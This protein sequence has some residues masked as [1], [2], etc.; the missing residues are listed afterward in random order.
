MLELSIPGRPGLRLEHL[1]LDY[2]GTLAVDGRLA[3][4]VRERLEVLA[5]RLN[6]HIITADTFGMAEVETGGL[7]VMLQLIG[8]GDQAA[9]KMAFVESL[10][11]RSVAAVGNGAN[12]RLMLG[13]AALSICVAG[14]E[15]AAVAALTASQ[16]VVRT[17]TDAL[18]LLLQPGRLVATLRV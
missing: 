9:A 1:V 2:N 10:G 7:P 14:V 6:V 5:V 8:K 17:G 3:Q 15:G 16:V 11:P 18:D 4:G 13:A 12:D